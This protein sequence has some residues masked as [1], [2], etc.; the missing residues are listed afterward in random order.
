MSQ[1]SEASITAVVSDC[2]S[3]QLSVFKDD[4][5]DIVMSSLST[6]KD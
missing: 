6:V 3:Q 5:K 2:I 4:M 1:T